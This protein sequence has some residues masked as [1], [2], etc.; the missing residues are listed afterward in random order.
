MDPVCF[1]VGGRPIYWYGVWMALAFA[2]AV[3]H[4]NVLARRQGRPP[5]F[6]S[7]LAFWIMLTGILG[8]RVLYVISEWP[9]YAG[10]PL[11]MLRVDRG[12]LIFYGGFLGAILAVA[13]RARRNREPFW[14]LAD[15]SI[16]A[17]PLGHLFGRIGCFMN[18][19]CYGSVC[20]LPWATWA[21][22]ARRHPVQLY[23][24][25]ANLAIY[26]VLLRRMLRPG[27]GEPGRVT[28][29]YLLLY[30]AARFIFEFLRGDER[31]AWGPLTAAQWLSLGLMLLGAALWRGLPQRLCRPAPAP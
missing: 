4:W 7:E 21:E 16:S 23:E 31:L 24:A 5:G 29:L 11:E 13:W 19:C 2:A 10:Q 14:S 28:G 20:S 27:P 8:A 26:L 1:T 18:G 3:T 6:G 12:G 17:V 25:A 9:Q 15:F 30:P 22:D